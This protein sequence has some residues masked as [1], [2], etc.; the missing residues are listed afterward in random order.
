MVPCLIGLTT[1]TALFFLRTF[2][3]WKKD[4]NVSWP[5]L[6]F[7]WVSALLLISSPRLRA[8]KLLVSATLCVT[9]YMFVKNG[10]LYSWPC[11]IALRPWLR[12]KRVRGYHI[13]CYSS[14][15]SVSVNI[16]PLILHLLTRHSVTTTQF[17]WPL[18]LRNTLRHRCVCCICV[19]VI[20]RC[21]HFLPLSQSIWYCR[22]RSARR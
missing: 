3:L 1:V 5:L 22:G 4:R 2:I 16:T 6:S 12:R 14:I 9:L 10:V 7:S 15:K 18:R 17:C 19:I 11:C 8:L 13:W 20:I 21:P